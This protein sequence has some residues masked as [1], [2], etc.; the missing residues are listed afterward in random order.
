[1]SIN[2]EGSLEKGFMDKIDFF[3]SWLK[4]ELLSLRNNIDII[5]ILYDIGRHELIATAIGDLL[6]KS[7]EL[8]DYVNQEDNPASYNTQSYN[9]RGKND[10]VD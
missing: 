3:N 10:M 6:V 5:I 4:D 9:D 2:T 8:A 1:M 7:Q